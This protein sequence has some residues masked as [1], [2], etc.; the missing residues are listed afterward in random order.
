MKFS[1][2]EKEDPS[3]SNT[4]NAGNLTSVISPMGSMMVYPA[5]VNAVKFIKA[6]YDSLLLKEFFAPD[7]WQ[8]E[9][10]QP[11]DILTTNA[12]KILSVIS[13]D[14]RG[15][16]TWPEVPIKSLTIKQLY[17]PD[18]GKADT[19]KLAQLNK[20]IGLGFTD[21]TKEEDNGRIRATRSFRDGLLQIGDIKFLVSPTQISFM[22][23][24]GY[25]YFPTMRTVGNPKIPTL[26]E[27]KSITLTLI[28]PNTDTINN[29]LLPLFAMYKRTPF[30]PLYNQD[31]CEF[32]KEIR[33]R[34]SDYIPVALDS[35]SIESVKGFPN[36]LQASLNIL[37]FQH[38]GVGE[39]FQA[40][41]TFRDVQ[42]QQFLEEDRSLE[43]IER[44]L[45]DRLVDRN[46]LRL[47]IIR[48]PKINHTY[49]FEKS[50]PFRAY[51]QAIIGDRK[52]VESDI[53]EIVTKT[54][55][56]RIPLSK[57][58]PTKE[59]NMLRYYLPEGNRKPIKFNYTHISDD[60]KVFTRKL[61]EA[62]LT[63]Q[64]QILKD[65]NYV[66]DLI[67][68]NDTTDFADQLHEKFYSRQ[69]F[70]DEMREQLADAGSFVEHWLGR[71]GINIQL[72]P[73]PRITG[74][75]S[76]MM[77]YAA[78]QFP[79]ATFLAG[80]LA[81]P[82]LDIEKASKTN[83]FFEAAIKL[84][85]GRF[86]FDGHEEP[87]DITRGTVIQY[88]NDE[89]DTIVTLTLREVTKLV[90]DRI[91]KSLNKG[92][93]KET[94]VKW[95]DFFNFL[96]NILGTDKESMLE[97]DSLP[98]KA[99]FLPIES[100]SIVIDNTRDIVDG[101]SMTF[102]NKFVPMNLQG[103]KYPYYQ[104]IGSEDINI[105]L[106][107]TSL[108]Q[109][110]V[111]GLKEKFSELNDRIINSTK[112]VLFH[113]PEL[114]NDLDPR[115]EVEVP[116]GNIFNVFGIQKLVYNSSNISS[117]GGQP[118]AWGMNVSLTEA[119]ITVKDYESITEVPNYDEIEDRILNLISRMGFDDKTGE[120]VIYQ[121]DINYQKLIDESKRIQQEASDNKL[122]GAELREF[123]NAIQ[124]MIND[125]EALDGAHSFIG[126]PT[127]SP[128]FN[129]TIKRPV[130]G[131]NLKKLNM[132][133]MSISFYADMHAKIL[134]EIKTVKT[135]VTVTQKS[136]AGTG[137]IPDIAVT[138]KIDNTVEQDSAV[139]NTLILYKKG[140]I[141]P[142]TSEAETTKFNEI[143]KEPNMRL[144][145]HNLI[146][147]QK[148]LKEIQSNIYIK[149]L[150]EP[151]G[152][153]K[154]LG[155]MLTDP[156]KV[157]T[158]LGAMGLGAVGW[159]LQGAPGPG[160]FIGGLMLTSAVATL[161]AT[162]VGT[163]VGAF[164]NKHKDR[165][166]TDFFKRNSQSFD[167]MIDGM[168]NSFVSELSRRIVRDPIIRK[169]LFG[170]IYEKD[171]SKILR[172]RHCNCY[173]DF[174]VPVLYTTQDYDTYGISDI[175]FAPD[176]YLY[177]KDISEIEKLAYS[178][179][180]IK[181][182]IKMGR[183]ST[184][185]SL[186]ENNET[187]KEIDAQE[188]LLF[189]YTSGKD[190]AKILSELQ[191]HSTV[192][193]PSDKDFIKNRLD[194]IQKFYT[195]IVLKNNKN[196]DP[197]APDAIKINLIR[198][199]R[200]KRII[201]LKLLQTAINTAIAGIDRK[202][203]TFVDTIISP[204][205]DAFG[206]DKF[207]FLEGSDENLT[208]GTIYDASASTLIRL[209]K[210][211]D[212]YF[213][214]Y[215]HTSTDIEK[216]VNSGQKLDAPD[217][218]FY[219]Q[220]LS[221]PNI[222]RFEE[223]VE[224]LLTQ[225]IILSNAIH[226]YHKGATEFTNLDTVPE[227]AMLGW[228]NWRNSESQVHNTGLLKEFLNEDNTKT[229]GFN[230][231]MFPTFKIYFVEED[232]R[233]LKNLDDYYSYDAIQSIDVVSNK[234]SAGKVATLTLSNSVGNL[235]NKLSLMREKSN[236]FEQIV[237]TS[238]NIFLGN[239]DI[240]PGAKMVIKI[241]YSAN[242]K[243]LKTHFVGRIIEMTPGPVV[244][245]V[246]QSY[247][248]QL[249][250]DI[251]KMH[252]GLLAAEKEHGDIASAIMDVVPSL[253]GLG[254]P[255]L[256][257]LNAGNFSG[258]NIKGVSKH[259]LDKF[260][261]SN[262]TS[263]VNA[264]MFT[265]D[266]PRDDNIYLP[267]SV[268]VD[269]R[270]HPTFDWIVYDQTVWQ[271]IN[272]LSL[273]HKN[274][275]PIVKLYNDDFLSTMQDL[276]ETVVVGDKSGYYKHTD[277]Y[278]LSTMSIKETQNTIDI[279]NRDIR[280]SLITLSN[281][282][283]SIDNLS[284]MRKQG[285]IEPGD[286]NPTS[287]PFITTNKD[288]KSV[289]KFFRNRRNATVIVYK[290]LQDLDYPSPMS[291]GALS[292]EKLTSGLRGLPGFTEKIMV[293]INAIMRVASMGEI[294][295]RE[296][297]DYVLAKTT[298]D[299]RGDN[300][301]WDT[302]FT[303]NIF[304]VIVGFNMN[305]K[306][307]KDGGALVN[308][309]VADF[310]HVEPFE[311]D[312]RKEKFVNDPRYER[313]QKHH[314]I[315][316][317]S[318]ILSNNIVLSQ[319]FNN[320]V[321]VYYFWEPKFYSNLS[322]ISAKDIGKLRSFTIKAFGDTRDKDVRLLETYQKN[323]DTNWWDIRSKSQQMLNSYIKKY[324]GGALKGEP[325]SWENLPSFVVV[326]LSLLQREVEK[327][328]RGTIQII[329]NPN[330][331]PMDILHIEDYLNDMHG[332]VEVEEV[333]H[334]ISPTGGFVTTITPSMITYDRDPSRMSDVSTV[335]NIINTADIKRNQER[336]IA[337]AKGAGSL[338][339]FGI[340]YNMFSKN[341]ASKV[342][343]LLGKG[344]G[345]ATMAFTAYEF[346]SAVWGGTIGVEKR[347]SK[348]IYDSVGNVFGRDCINFSTLIYHGAPYMCGF[349]GVD[350]T[351]IKTLINHQIKG[352]PMMTRLAA[353]S[354]P[355]RFWISKHGDFDMTQKEKLVNIVAP[356]GWMSS[357]LDWGFQ[358]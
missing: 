217:N 243:F 284:L 235:T 272:E 185:L 273:H 126:D 250:H 352:Q 104:H 101:W 118:G 310:L 285:F 335:Q 50:E 26:Q 297:E 119:S 58:R 210:H 95:A 148:E 252:F 17:R 70:Y 236:L 329:G 199:A 23:Q 83:K 184:L 34:H 60:F 261:L 124:R 120:F 57:F 205:E 161:G 204:V 281:N 244:T 334:S 192:G 40:L 38:M 251:L 213:D 137:L 131:S 3:I 239:L 202:D 260:L 140:I 73:A 49:N 52:F 263:R 154:H 341:R 22:T 88:V 2:A 237:S 160:T 102:A 296:F 292:I 215:F 182:M 62:R 301:T 259:V 330:I 323:I 30:V 91:N 123:S 56:K 326:P 100:D 144:I 44:Q 112:V 208:K 156:A 299:A 238:D 172:S 241:G 177:N 328:Y 155:R 145:I 219:Q 115:L 274:T 268:E 11:G 167:T 61:S 230:S 339:G 351:T 1:K 105:S 121:Y 129:G 265:Q 191:I 245:I 78:F 152:F 276:R 203:E 5:H 174:D 304:G 258:K 132:A 48:S 178:H 109:G 150:K 170:D 72:E 286:L 279:W 221:Q 198:S 138:K 28:F 63:T 282:F 343:Q 266:N 324:D 93:D 271:A 159:A 345:A 134:S 139:K 331:E 84:I 113:A 224:T 188:D 173:K 340:G 9:K 19:E 264:G 298:T 43:I 337:T 233:L 187:L 220:F 54:D 218:T 8:L 315:T 85:G 200:I 116:Q 269:V 319:D 24:N 90:A 314:L 209:Q 189:S 320:A 256:L 82:I 278:S 86:T 175:K 97:S 257:G 246:A 181:R 312:N 207:K 158:S 76:F 348:F 290:L 68:K 16:V 242:D 305:A 253:E 12:N 350:Y 153:W 303:D 147:R 193:D 321:S 157:M 114:I 45:E 280:N 262:I 293:L 325:P 69:D 223:V 227:I 143:I 354:D 267:F 183:I 356:G 27:I 232:G 103:F 313:I 4:S 89:D 42:A 186:E 240:K 94:K 47:N 133:I 51:Y 248:A 316:D 302:K 228:W 214:K 67:L 307:L 31:I 168:K 6:T 135:E 332:T 346:L 353:S 197:I 234:Y 287:T 18:V 36:T 66:M 270:N 288:L 98:F 308:L 59:E 349:G 146:R 254:K 10:A 194:E 77:Q 195:D 249:N 25:E 277:S 318:D 71:Y 291:I 46:A 107:I 231:K 225:I 99:S 216:S 141:T 306:A 289:I 55:G 295:D 347:Y 130:K 275:F 96:L 125:T 357:M 15:L 294:T 20:K 283:N 127:N 7:T 39:T 311:T 176:F 171:I 162:E 344:F 64:T 201:K 74:L 163:A 300:V 333:V 317:Q 211:I 92:T 33:E 142:I 255:P 65:T 41:E 29:Q 37:P 21:F 151:D 110:R 164:L 180:A 179:N 53:G 196:K 338:L 122:D 165:A 322:G 169:R 212:L 247:G 136:G 222:R 309:K 117:I 206:V 111:Q 190:K 149:M 79:N 108:Q 35:I 342:G 87:I 14:D 75:L 229:R 32:F 336:W 81:G 327:M 166:I 80:K 106:N 355:G 128:L 13:N 358:E 226:D